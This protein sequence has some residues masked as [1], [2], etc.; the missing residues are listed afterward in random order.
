[1][2]RKG[3]PFPHRQFFESKRYSPPQIVISLLGKG[4][5]LATIVRGPNL[6]VA[7]P[8]SNFAL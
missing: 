6:N 8:T 4:T 7:F 3:T 5:R 1:M 2:G